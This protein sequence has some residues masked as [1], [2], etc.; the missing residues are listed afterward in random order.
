MH[1]GGNHIKTMKDKADNSCG[2]GKDEL[3]Q[4]YK[5]YTGY[6]IQEKETRHPR[7]ENAG[8]SILCTPTNDECTPPPPTPTIP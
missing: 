5:S 1:G 2:R 7:C 4:A 6:A 3:T 8:D